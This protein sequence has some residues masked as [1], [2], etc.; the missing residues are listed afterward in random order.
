MAITKIQ[1]ES[2]NLSDTYDFTGT[3]TGA[4]ESN[5]PAFYATGDGSTNVANAT[6]NRIANQREVFDNGGCYNHTSSTVTLNGISVP[7]FRFAPN[8]AGLYY[9]IGAVKLNT[10]N[11]NVGLVNNLGGTGGTESYSSLVYG[12]GIANN[13]VVVSGYSLMN[14]TGNNMVLTCYQES[15]GAIQTN[16]AIYTTYF[17]GFLVKKS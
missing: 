5:T 1:S 6:L 16:D 12:T 15:G 7:D 9:F 10:A 14:G 17:G 2:L 3:V 4:G 11:F 8:V 13:T